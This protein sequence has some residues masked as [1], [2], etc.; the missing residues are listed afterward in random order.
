MD[1]RTREAVIRKALA[2]VER[3]QERDFRRK[4]SIAVLVA[5]PVGGLL[6]WLLAFG[7]QRHVLEIALGDATVRLVSYRGPYELLV[8]GAED[9]TFV[10]GGFGGVIRREIGGETI[11][12]VS[13]DWAA[14][15]LTEQRAKLPP[16]RYAVDFT[17]N[18][19]AFTLQGS[20]LL[21]GG[22]RW[23]L[24]PGRRLEINVDNLPRVDYATQMPDP[25]AVP[26]DEEEPGP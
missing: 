7:Y 9:P 15:A 26:D 16:G 18:G 25:A 22:R 13:Y 2:D 21:C 19:L 1:D 11:E 5:L 20:E 3:A 8:T 6:V 17:I 4:L 23:L 24:A 10:S 12:P 14:L